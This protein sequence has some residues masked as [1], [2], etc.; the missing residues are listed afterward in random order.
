MKAQLAQVV[1][2]WPLGASLAAAV[3]MQGLWAGRRRSALNE[4]L[5][6][7]RRPLQT[8]ALAAPGGEPARS[9]AVEGSLQM[10]AGALERLEREINGGSI[11]AVR[12]PL[13]AQALL[14]SGLCRWNARAVVAG[15]SLEL[16]WRAGEATVSGDRW[17]LAQALDNLIANALEHGGPEVV[18]EG[19][20]SRGRLAVSVVD[21]G[22]GAP[23]PGPRRR[24]GHG[25]LARLSGRRL[26]GHGLRLVRRAA[27]AH[28][29]GFSLRFTARGTEAVLELPLAS[30]TGDEA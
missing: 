14:E 23:G 22:G 3:A 16:R 11:G 8:L 26:R 5:H 7:L 30:R 27:A 1:A 29:G 10:A 6:E 9:S 15:R 4:A 28:R 2:A 25:P 13:C 21:S 18:V 19:A 24:D 17:Q 20:I 12:A